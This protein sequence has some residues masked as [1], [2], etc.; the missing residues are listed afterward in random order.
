MILGL[1]YKEENITQN[2]NFCNCFIE[3]LNGKTIDV[4]KL[5]YL[6]RD[7]WA[8]GRVSRVLDYERLF[9][10]MYIKLENDNF[11]VCFH[12]KAINEILSLN[13]TKKIIGVSM[14]SHPIVKY[15]EYVL[16]HAIEEVAS[17]I[18]N[19]DRRDKI[20]GKII[21]FNTL[22]EEFVEVGGFKFNLLTDDDLIY[23]LKRHIDKSPFAKVWFYREY[24]LKALWKTFADYK[25]FF[26]DFADE[27]DSDIEQQKRKLFYTYRREIVEKYFKTIDPNE[28][29]KYRYHVE[30]KLETEYELQIPD[31]NI[32]IKDKIVKLNS[33]RDTYEKDKESERRK[34]QKT[35][36]LLYFPI[37]FLP[38]RQDF[39]DF[40]KREIEILF[41]E[42]K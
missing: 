33:L 16:Q 42:N 4:D 40:A 32:F 26:K 23:L 29:K 2:R 11:Y 5:D 30:D 21:S 6:A 31:I 14:H 24:K 10:S 3:L 41:K 1:T 7:Q 8:T 9:S 20:V 13:E 25:Y 22:K 38:Q 19:T 34:R 35:Y 36:F 12:K 18:D 17:L 27:N 39:I 15:D 37:E 28:E